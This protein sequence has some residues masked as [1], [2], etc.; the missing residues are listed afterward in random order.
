MIAI[1][2]DETQ[3]LFSAVKNGSSNKKSFG[4][5]VKGA[6]GSVKTHVG[7][8]SRIYI[9]AAAAGLGAGGGALLA[10]KK[11]KKAAEAKGLKPGTPE[12]KA[13]IRKYMAV[14]AAAGFGAGAAT[15]ELA[16]MGTQ[17]VRPMIGKDKKF[18]DAW[19]NRGHINLKGK[20]WI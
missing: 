20:K 15:S 14:G 17:V 2:F 1:V 19:K 3:K 4:Q 18:K 6:A 13:F 9:D 11:A 5:R 16:R 7:N 10:R 12:Y 8:N